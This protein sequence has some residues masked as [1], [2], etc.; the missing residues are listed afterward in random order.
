MASTITQSVM[1]A[2]QDKQTEMPLMAHKRCIVVSTKVRAGRTKE[3]AKVALLVS[4]NDLYVYIE[5]HLCVQSP[6]RK[7]M[8]HLIGITQDGAIANIPLP[9]DSVVDTFAGDIT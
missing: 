8:Q 3:P 2:M 4:Y 9:L 6:I 5:A 1:Q 7:E